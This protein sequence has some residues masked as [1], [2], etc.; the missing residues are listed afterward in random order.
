MDKYNLLYLKHGGNPPDYLDEV[1]ESLKTSTVELSK[2]RESLVKGS[3]GKDY[4]WVGTSR[5]VERK[6]RL[7]TTNA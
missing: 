2:D 6:E 5:I 1:A 7:K 3:L 4:N